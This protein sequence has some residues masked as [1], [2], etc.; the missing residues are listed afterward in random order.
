MLGS[1]NS[2]P[3]RTLS[4]NFY[5]LQFHDWLLNAITE[6]TAK[7]EHKQNGLENKKDERQNEI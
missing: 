1:D 5:P 2:S 3:S 6:S 4:H 7:E